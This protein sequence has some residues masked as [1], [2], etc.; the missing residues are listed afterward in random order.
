MRVIR[1]ICLRLGRRKPVEAQLR[2][3]RTAIIRQYH[4]IRPIRVLKRRHANSLQIATRPQPPRA[5][6]Y[7]PRPHGIRPQPPRR[8]DLLLVA[9]N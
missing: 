9:R 7:E 5:G 1:Q 4:R 8:D 6:P 3:L 2:I